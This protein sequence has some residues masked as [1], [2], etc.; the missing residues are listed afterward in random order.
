[1]GSIVFLF[2]FYWS[3]TFGK[4]C[5]VK[6]SAEGNKEYIYNIHIYKLKEAASCQLEYVTN[7]QQ[8][9]FTWTRVKF[10]F[11]GTVERLC[12]EFYFWL[13]VFYNDLYSKIS[14]LPVI[15]LGGLFRLRVDPKNLSFTIFIFLH[16]LSI[17]A[18]KWATQSS[19]NLNQHF[20]TLQHKFFCKFCRPGSF[21]WNR[22]SA[23]EMATSHM[24]TDSSRTLSFPIIVHRP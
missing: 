24:W 14:I 7:V 15:M 10:V 22:F 21:D 20:F 3:L 19:S 1:M 12:C 9:G 5:Y 18:D 4:N 6:I 11:T 17:S 23:G 16:H 2:V 13:S 8:N